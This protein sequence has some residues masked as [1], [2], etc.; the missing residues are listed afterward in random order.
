[1]VTLLFSAALNVLRA[2]QF[3]SVEMFLFLL[4]F[5]VCEAVIY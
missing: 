3:L 5:G 4:F 2:L 1:M